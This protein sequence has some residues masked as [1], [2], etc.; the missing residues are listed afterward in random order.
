LL[1]DCCVSKPE[2]RARTAH[3]AATKA[4]LK[5]ARAQPKP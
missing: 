1:F 2:P 5:S 3:T 4:Q